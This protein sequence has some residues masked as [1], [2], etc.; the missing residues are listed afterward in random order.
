MKFKIKQ[1]ILLK[2]LNY[3]SKA[4]TTKNI[5]PILNG[6]K[7]EINKKELIMIGSND[8]I[9]IQSKIPLNK[10]EEITQEGSIIIPGIYILEIIK[11]LPNNI[12]EIETDGTKIIIKTK[13]SKYTL[14][15]INISEYPDY[16]FNLIKNP[17]IIKQNDFKDLITKT[18][19]AISQQEARPLLTGINFKMENEKLTVLATDS[20]RLAQKTLILN[21]KNNQIID[22]VIP[23]K[24]L[25]E[26]TKILN[27]DQ[28]NLE[29]HLSNN[30]ILFK[31][32]NII[33]QSRLLNGTYPHVS[34]Q[35][36]QDFS[37]EIEVIG[38]ELYN[39]IDR[40]SLLTENE[41]NTLHLEINNDN[42]IIT[43]DAL[44]VGKVEE[45]MKIIN[46]NKKNIK[47]SFNS[48]FMMDALKSLT[49]EKILILLNQEK[50]PI[51]LKEINNNDILQL[52]LPIKTF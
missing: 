25:I 44:E 47:L 46:K 14:N 3:I 7:F 18:V 17:I 29:L 23:G 8:N 50:P 4:L 11:K 35:I 49:T 28:E 36:P 31:F 22:I 38:N 24:N 5:I 48:K 51:I 12:I 15:G 32:S 16:N 27:D 9:I 1:D 13:N 30:N 33:F 40:A 34:N 42:L 20:Y 10:L 45:R 43:S 41:K 52:I 37:I 6:I 21:N 26:L 39:I 19:F 2:N